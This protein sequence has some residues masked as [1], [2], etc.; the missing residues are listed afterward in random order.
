MKEHYLLYIRTCWTPFIA[1]YTWSKNIF[2]AGIAYLSA[3]RS[4]IFHQSCRGKHWVNWTKQENKEKINYSLGAATDHNDIFF[5][6]VSDLCCFPRE[7]PVICRFTWLKLFC[8]LATTKALRSSSS[9]I[10]PTEAKLSIFLIRH[11][12]SSWRSASRKGSCNKE[13]RRHH[14]PRICSPLPFDSVIIFH[15]III[16][17][18]FTRWLSRVH[19]FHFSF[20]QLNNAGEFKPSLFLLTRELL[21]WL[22]FYTWYHSKRPWGHS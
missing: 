16:S 14:V 20:F 10:T 22:T 1:S 5:E 19:V 2:T 21:R 12:L 4:R 13:V 7:S 8:F 9:C 11:V 6:F 3:R 15:V 18:V 17:H